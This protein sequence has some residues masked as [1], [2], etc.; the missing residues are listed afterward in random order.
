MEFTAY[1]DVLKTVYD[2]Q[3]LELEMHAPALPSAI[4]TLESEWGF[5]LDPALRNAWL[6]ADGAGEWMPVFM[7]PGFLTGYDF[8]SVGEVRGR[9]AVWDPSS[10][11]YVGYEQEKPRD[12][13]IAPGWFHPQWLPFASFDG[14]TL[15]LMQDYTPTPEGRVGQIIAFVH[16]P[17]E[18]CYVADDFASFLQG[19]LAAIQHDP[20][21]FLIAAEEW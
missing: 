21:E 6:Q 13:R 8:L 12:R 20:E 16:D 11:Q 10:R 2:S 1:L 3:G 17:D 7:R 15:L 18:V 14:N 9:R 5:S 4:A 19:S